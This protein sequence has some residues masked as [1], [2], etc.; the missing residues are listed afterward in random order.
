MKAKQPKVKLVTF[1]VKTTVTNDCVVE[2]VRKM[3]QDYMD[4]VTMRDGVVF[5]IVSKPR[6]EDVG[7]R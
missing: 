4:N 7:P 1:K 2:V 5:K 6:V 3:I